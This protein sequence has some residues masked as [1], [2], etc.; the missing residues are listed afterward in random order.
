[1]FLL[2]WPRPH[3]H[4]GGSV[5][6]FP[7][8]GVA[9]QQLRELRA[10]LARGRAEETPPPSRRRQAGPELGCAPAGLGRDGGA[11]SFGRGVAGKST[12]RILNP[13]TG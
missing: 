13:R 2:A 1:M 10:D 11:R 6:R 12:S 8:P 5:G 4:P 7:L 9:P 3:P